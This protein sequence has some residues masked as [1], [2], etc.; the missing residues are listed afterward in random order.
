MTTSNDPQPSLL[1]FSDDWGRHPS[2]CQHLTARLLDR[3]DVTWVNTIGMRVPKFDKATIS[4]G[5]EKLRDWSG[6]GK[7]SPGKASPLPA[8]LCVFSPKMWP[9]FGSSFDRRINRELLLRQL[10]PIVA[11]LPAPPIA[12]TTI[13]I[14]ADLIGRLPVARWVYYC[15]DDFSV[16]PGLDQNAL[17]RMEGPLIDRAD[18]LIAASAA[19]QHKFSG[20][21]RSAHLLTHG[22]DL[23]L[24]INHDEESLPLPAFEGIPRPLVVF[25]GLVD[26]RLDIAILERLCADLT[27]GTVVLVGPESDPD[28]AL[29]SIPGLVRRPAM[30]YKELPR[31]AHETKVLVMPY[32]DLPVTRMIQPLKLA[33]YLATGKPVVARDLPANLPWADA[34]DLADSPAAFSE[35]VRTRLATGLVESQRVARARLSEESWD[36]KTEAFERWVFGGESSEAIALEPTE[37]TRR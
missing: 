31:L 1:V 33:E 28:P 2:S 11:N 7:P 30:P 20:L 12:I 17:R 3:H 13:P 26:R 15:V 9:W 18:V 23:G 25:W 21:D 22:V 35:A 8:R 36:A 4:R 29:N 6:L 19:L 34:L 32:A 5:M 24:W 27:E 10:T 16:W 14:V 37:V